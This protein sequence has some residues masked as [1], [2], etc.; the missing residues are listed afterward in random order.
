MFF[1]GIEKKLEIH[2]ST[3]CNLLREPRSFWEKVVQEAGASILNEMG[4]GTGT[5]ISYLLSESSLFVYKNHLTMITCGTTT[6]VNSALCLARHF[7]LKEIR[8][9][10]YERK[11]EYF[12]N[13][14][15][16]DFYKDVRDLQEHFEGMKGKAY[17]FGQE[18][19]HH[20]MLFH[21]DSPFHPFHPPQG[22]ETCEILMYKLDPG[23]CRKFA[24][25]A[26]PREK[27][28]LREEFIA[29]LEKHFPLF[30]KQEYFFEPMGYSLNALNGPHYYT[31]HVTPEEESSYVSFE[32]NYSPSSESSSSFFKALLETLTYIFCPKSF[33]VIH[34]CRHHTDTEEN[35][36]PAGEKQAPREEPTTAGELMRAIH[37]SHGFSHG[38]KY[39]CLQ[40]VNEQLSC[41][42]RVHFS[43]HF[44]TEPH[45]VR[46][47][48]ITHKMNAL[49]SHQMMERA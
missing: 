41:G 9:L 19:H 18:D 21:F 31:L 20:L 15:S 33:D 48:E 29:P 47:Y 22:D 30:K 28:S 40:N 35:P 37:G 46:A 6:L 12:P 10:I 14:Q 38:D 1:E 49:P 26:T 34:F 4:N 45:P 36:A 23:V 7:G 17:R 43:S 42:Y 39:H 5:C 24:E 11:N 8:S 44:L 32:C 16:S 2:F 13:Q 27:A 25:N 3:G